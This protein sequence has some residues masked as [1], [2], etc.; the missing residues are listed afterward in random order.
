MLV[1]SDVCVPVVF[2]W[3]ETGVPGGDPPVWLGDYMTIPHADAGYWTRVA[4]VKGERVTNTPTS[5]PH[6]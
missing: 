3:E 6:L 5:Q 1:G 4:P 2:V